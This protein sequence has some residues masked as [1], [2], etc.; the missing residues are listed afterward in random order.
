MDLDGDAKTEMDLI[1]ITLTTRRPAVI[2]TGSRPRRM[3]VE[4]LTGYDLIVA[5]RPFVAL[6][7]ELP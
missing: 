5:E 1:T 7:P 4:L 6:E 3:P 2:P